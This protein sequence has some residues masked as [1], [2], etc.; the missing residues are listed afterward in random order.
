MTDAVS[1][2]VAVLPTQAPHSRRQKLLDDIEHVE[3]IGA[4]LVSDNYTSPA[5]CLAEKCYRF[6]SLPRGESLLLSSGSYSGIDEFSCHGLAPRFDSSL[7]RA[8]LSRL[9]ATRMSVLKLSEDLFGRDIW[10]VLQ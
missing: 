4:L 7:K 6:S 2:R 10:F 8:E 5:C 3:P 1:D 9:K